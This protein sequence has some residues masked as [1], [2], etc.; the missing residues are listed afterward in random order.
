MGQFDYI[1][2]TYGKQFK[3]GQLV[4]ALGKRG[5]VTAADHYVHVR[6]DSLKH[7]NPYHPSDVEPLRIET[8]EPAP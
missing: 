7:S 4:L 8:S 2:Q 6:L 5:T 3:R 1:A